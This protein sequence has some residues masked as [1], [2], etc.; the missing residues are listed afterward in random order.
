MTNTTE[1]KGENMVKPGQKPRITLSDVEAVFEARHDV[2]EPL[3]ASE[4]G[5]E[6]NCTRRTALTKLDRLLEN[7][8]V[9]SKKVGGRARVWW[10]PVDRADLEGHTESVE[11]DTQRREATEELFYDIDLPGSGE[12]LEGRREAV[13]DIYE[14]LKEHGKGQRADFKDVVDVEATGYGGKDPFN[15]FYVNCMENGAVLARFPD[16][17]PPGEGG[18]VYQYVGDR[19]E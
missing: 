5:D 15:S 11:T 4:I 10:L 8:T 1:D 13:R 12:N 16:I 7:G 3:T 14:Y 19:G 9:E 17:E 2:A 6:L 18:H